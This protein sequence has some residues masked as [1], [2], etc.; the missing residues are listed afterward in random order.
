MDQDLETWLS[1]LICNTTTQ[2]ALVIKTFVIFSHLSTSTKSIA[3][4][5]KRDIKH[6]SKSG[7]TYLY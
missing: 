6:A 4:H 2:I 3:I 5:G 7:A 1:L